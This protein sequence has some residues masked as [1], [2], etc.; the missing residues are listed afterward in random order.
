MISPLLFLSKRR[1]ENQD[2]D[3]R[4]NNLLF[5]V[6]LEAFVPQEILSA[7]LKIKIWKLA[8]NLRPALSIGSTRSGSRSCL[9]HCFPD[10]P[11]DRHRGGGHPP[12]PA[13]PPCVRVRTR[14]FELVTLTPIDQ[15]WKS[16]RCEVGVGKP[17]RE[18][19]GPSEVPGA[20]STTGR[21][22]SQSRTIRP[23]PPSGRPED[24]HLQVTEHAQ[25]TT[26]PLARRTLPHV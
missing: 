12:T 7:I 19:F 16:E 3:F 23:S 10:S 14:R 9:S 20:A 26:K 2:L 17:N 21:V 6:G 11:S 22:A 25:H 13:T 1:Y 24:F 18:G 8:F 4:P 15:R 5:F